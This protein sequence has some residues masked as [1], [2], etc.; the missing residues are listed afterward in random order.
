MR[1]PPEP[2]PEE[3]ET[4]DENPQEETKQERPHKIEPG[5]LFDFAENDNN[6]NQATENDE[7][8]KKDI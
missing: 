8:T 4:P 6:D 2:E 1:F 5:D 3:E 7:A